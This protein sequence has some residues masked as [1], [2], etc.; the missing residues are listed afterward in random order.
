MFMTWSLSACHPGLELW[1]VPGPRVLLVCSA[2]FPRYRPSLGWA[3]DLGALSW[4]DDTMVAAYV[5]PRMIPMLVWCDGR[6]DVGASIRRWMQAGCA[7]MV[8]FACYTCDL[9]VDVLGC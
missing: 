4:D 3:D 2:F 7:S 9:E 5:P 1:T 8:S 6:L